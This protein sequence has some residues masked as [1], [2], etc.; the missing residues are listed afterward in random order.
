MMQEI[1]TGWLIHGGFARR[2][3]LIIVAFGL[4]RLHRNKDDTG[5][6]KQGGE[7]EELD[8]CWKEYALIPY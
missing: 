5:D 2:R 1:W 3:T 7:G 8:E 6:L 4:Y